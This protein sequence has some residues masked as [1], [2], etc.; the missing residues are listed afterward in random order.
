MD[1][2]ARPKSKRSLDFT[3]PRALLS[4]SATER[5]MDGDRERQLL[6]VGHWCADVSV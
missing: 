1:T 4:E 5:Q 2:G 6:E 3:S